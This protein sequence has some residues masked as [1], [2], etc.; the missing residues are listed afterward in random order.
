MARKKKDRKRPPAKDGSDRGRHSPLLSRA[1]FDAVVKLARE[2]IP[3]TL[4]GPMLGPTPSGVGCLPAPLDRSIVSRWRQLAKGKKTG[5]YVD[6]VAALR[7]SEPMVEDANLRFI[8]GARDKD[9]RSAAWLLERK[10]PARYGKAVKLG[11]DPANPAPILTST[12]QLS[13][14]ER[15]RRLERAKRVLGVLGK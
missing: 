13:P 2:G 6:L 8:L 9:W 14:E 1:V 10:F 11:G 4:I 5:I 15:A 12:V 7:A 3:E